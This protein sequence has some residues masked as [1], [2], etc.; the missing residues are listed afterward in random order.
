M[1]TEAG[2]VSKLLLLDREIDEP[3]AGALIVTVQVLTPLGP[4]VAGLHARLDTRIGAVAVRLI[5]A[6]CELLPRVA[7]TVAP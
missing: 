6:G 4:R 3:P 7:V 1:V 2:T 5:V